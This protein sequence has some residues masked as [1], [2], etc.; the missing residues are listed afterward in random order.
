M[1]VLVKTI[2][3]LN[4]LQKSKE[5][6]GLTEI[7][8][9]TKINKTTCHRILYTLMNDHI[10]EK[11]ERQG[12]YRLGT[13]LLELG[14]TV[15]NKM[16]LRQRALP[17]LTRLANETEE[18]AFLC[19]KNSNNQGMCIER[20]EGKHVQVLAFKVGDTWPLYLG[21]ASR[22]IL[23]SLSEE[24]ISEILAGP[25]IPKTPKTPTDPQ[26]YLNMVE[27]I[28]KK[29]YSVCSDDVTLG[30]TSIGAPIHD[31]TGKVIG[32]ISLSTVMMRPN[33]ERQQELI[34]LVTQAA[35]T[36]SQSMGYHH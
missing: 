23:A 11:G 35:K 3:I 20:I 1:L 17:E 28:R 24:E 21:A 36:I 7:S 16:D 12:T 10:V 31:H 4:T 9:E 2:T 15:Q 19:I 27:D 18:T 22:T 13:R 25:I 5:D 30:V 8:K 32:A 14:S 26:L 34:Q 6:L 29:G 33:K